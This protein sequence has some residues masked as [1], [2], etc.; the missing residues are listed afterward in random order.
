MENFKD[1]DFVEGVV[2][3]IVRF[4]ES[5]KVTRSVDS[6]GVLLLIEVDKGDMPVLIGAKGQNINAVRTLARVIGGQNSERVNLKVVE[7]RKDFTN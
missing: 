4:P 5:V 2:R 3:S 7:P 6:L 1:L